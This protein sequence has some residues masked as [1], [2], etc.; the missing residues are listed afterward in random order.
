MWP[1]YLLLEYSTLHTPEQELNPKPKQP[2]KLVNLVSLWFEIRAFAG[3]VLTGHLGL[4]KPLWYP[5]LGF[6][7]G[8]EGLQEIRSSRTWSPGEQH[9]EGIAG[10]LWKFGG[11]FWSLSPMIG[12]CTPHRP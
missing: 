12:R 5:R 1:T 3:F 9:E 7:D 2:A 10:V 4:L 6:N 8:A 11:W